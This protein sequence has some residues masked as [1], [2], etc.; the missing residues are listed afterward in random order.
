MARSLPGCA[1]AKRARINITNTCL[2]QRL[3]P[4]NS[5]NS[6]RR[7]QTSVTHEPQTLPPALVLGRYE[8]KSQLGAGGMGEVYLAQDTKTRSH[9]RP[10]SSSETAGQ[11]DPLVINNFE[12]EHQTWL[13]P[14]LHRYR[15]R[16]HR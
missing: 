3:L 15:G 2:S 1:W 12:Q 7:T 14:L 13:P 8:I 5:T 6:V 10:G 16:Q 9:S 4:L 11:D